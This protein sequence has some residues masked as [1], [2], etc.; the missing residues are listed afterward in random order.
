MANYLQDESWEIT[1][2]EDELLMKVFL[3]L[4]NVLKSVKQISQENH[5]HVSSVY[6]IL[7]K[8]EQKKLIKKSGIISNNSTKISL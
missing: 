3:S 2:F 5:I 1:F 6:H 7:K 8:L 4:V